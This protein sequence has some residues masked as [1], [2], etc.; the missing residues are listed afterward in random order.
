MSKVIIP[1]VSRHVHFVPDGEDRGHMVQRGGQPLHAVVIFVHNERTVNLA[2]TD[3]DGMFH[4][5]IGV[6]LV[7]PGDELPGGSY[8]QWMAYQVK[9][10]FAHDVG[11][12]RPHPIPVDSEGNFTVLIDSDGNIVGPE[13]AKTD[14]PISPV[15]ADLLATTATSLKPEDLA[16]VKVGADMTPAADGSAQ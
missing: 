16:G 9:A 1:D 3:H 6:T 4:T 10:A 11:A 5:R 12:S 2:I 13:V 7:Q 15:L 14:G 8:C